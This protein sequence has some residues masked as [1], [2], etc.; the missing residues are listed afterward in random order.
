MGKV[1][2]CV[3]QV[4]QGTI[5][6]I[7]VRGPPTRDLS[8]WG[9]QPQQKCSHTTLMQVP[10]DKPLCFSSTPPAP[11]NYPIHEVWVQ[12]ACTMRVDTPKQI[13]PPFKATH[14]VPASHPTMQNALIICFYTCTLNSSQYA[15][16]TVNKYSC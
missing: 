12:L 10:L 13:I 5:P 14:K 2:P 16:L 15:Q 9:S 1:H 3:P 7:E 11:L 6:L 4:K 8:D